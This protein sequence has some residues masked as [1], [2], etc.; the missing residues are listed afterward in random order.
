MPISAVEPPTG[1]IL[2][3]SA[4]HPRRS[5]LFVPG[6]NP[7]ALEK[8]CDLPADGLIFDLEDAVVPAIKTQA[9]FQV[10]LALQQGGHRRRERIVRVNALESPWGAADLA[11]AAALPIDA[12]LLPKVER[13][14]QVLRAHAVLDHSGAPAGLAIW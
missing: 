13:A 8:A 14:D 10:A 11:A 5:V 3:P 7:G 9:R 2:P 1:P 6:D 4:L 12:V